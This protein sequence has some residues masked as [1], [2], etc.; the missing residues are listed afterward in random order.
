MMVKRG[1]ISLEKMKQIKRMSLKGYRRGYNELYKMVELYNQRP[2]DEKTGKY[3]SGEK[4][5]K[6]RKKRIEDLEE[7]AEI[8]KGGG[9]VTF[10]INSK[11]KIEM[12]VY[13]K[14]YRRG[15]F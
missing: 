7:M 3:Y 2:F 6:F 13:G 5:K 4:V 15:R 12:R 1:R 10:R 11:R 9:N 8:T 14:V